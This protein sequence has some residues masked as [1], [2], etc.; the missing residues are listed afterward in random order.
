MNDILDDDCIRHTLQH[1]S[2]I[3]CLRL[4]NVTTR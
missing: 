3:E 2:L 4:E 1:L